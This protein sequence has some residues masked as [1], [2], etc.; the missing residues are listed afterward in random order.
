MRVLGF[1]ATFFGFY[2]QF[3]IPKKLLNHSVSYFPRL[4]MGLLERLG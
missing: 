3:C 2:I 1:G 4:Q